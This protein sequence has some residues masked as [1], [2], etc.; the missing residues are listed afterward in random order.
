MSIDVWLEIDT[1]GV[2]PAD[3][4]ERRFVPYN[5]LPTL[6]EA[7][8]ALPL[9]DL[10]QAAEVRDIVRH[11]AWRMRTSPDLFARLDS[12]E[13]ETTVAQCLALLDALASD[14]AANPMATFRVL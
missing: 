5:L 9:L 2:E 8:A 10:V 13:S 6:R 14:C 7:G 11:S 1:G 12:D 4:T 3:V